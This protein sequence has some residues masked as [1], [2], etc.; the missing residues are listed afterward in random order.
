[1]L[2]IAII[3][4]QI[5]I[6]NRWLAA[7]NVIIHELCVVVSQRFHFAT[8]K[9]SWAARFKRVTRALSF[10]N[11]L[12]FC[13]YF[14]FCTNLLIYS[15]LHYVTVHPSMLIL[16]NFRR[17]HALYTHPSSPMSGQLS[18]RHKNNTKIYYRQ[19]IKRSKITTTT[20]KR[21]TLAYVAVV[22]ENNFK[23]LFT[24]NRFL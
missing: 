21:K 6:I 11:Q 17:V 23:A 14:S 8:D 1:M 16:R 24:V 20:T 13:L 15:M 22:V 7:K 4:M 10:K 18:S 12:F 3:M 2:K 19:T 9:S 5:V